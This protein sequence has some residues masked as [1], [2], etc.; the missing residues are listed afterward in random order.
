MKKNQK[1]LL[2]KLFVW[3]V[4]ITFWGTDI[5]A[6]GG[7]IV[8][9]DLT[10]T[11]VEKNALTTDVYT[12]SVVGENAYNAFSVFDVYEDNTVNL[13]LPENTENLLN[14]VY[15]KKS[16]IN[17][18]LNSYKDNKIG[19][20]VFFLNPH[21]I[22]VSSKGRINVG[23]LSLSTP[24]REFLD[25]LVDSHGNISS[26]ATQA[27]LDGDTPIDETGVISIDGQ[28]NAQNAIKVDSGNFEIK[29]EMS[30]NQ[31][32]DVFDLVVNTLPDAFSGNGNID[33]EAKNDIVA[34]K[35]SKISSSSDVNDSGDIYMWADKDAYLEKDSTISAVASGD[36]DAGNVEF[37][38]ND[39]V[40][41]RGG[42]LD[43]Y[44]EKGKSGY[45][46]VDP[47]E[48]Y[49]EDDYYSHAE[50]HYYLADE[51]I[52]ISDGV[53]ISSRAITFGKEDNRENHLNENSTASSG[54]LD[55]KADTIDVGKDVYIITK[56]NN[57]FASDDINMEAEKINLGEGSVLNAS[58][59]IDLK[60]GN[61]NLTAYHN[62]DGP[63]TNTEAYVKIEDNV[64]IKGYDVNISSKADCTRYLDE[65]YES[66][67]KVLD[68][69]DTIVPLPVAYS[70][71][72][73]DSKIEVGSGA[74][75]EAV[76][77]VNLDSEA[78]TD[79]SMTSVGWIANVAWGETNTYS[80][81]LLDG[82]Q[83]DAGNSVDINSVADT[84]INMKAIAIAFG[85]TRAEAA[86]A[87]GNADVI[88]K[89]NIDKDSN[90]NAA[91][92]V[93]V[94]SKTDKKLNVSAG[95]SAYEDGQLALAFAWSKSNIDNDAKLGGDIK[96]KNLKVG[97]EVN[98][99][100]NHNTATSQVGT[101]GIVDTLKITKVFAA[102]GG[103]ADAVKSKI[104]G[105]TPSPR[106]QSSSKKFGLSAAF[107]LSDHV[108]MSEA[109][110]LENTSVDASNN[111]TV[112]SKIAAEID[113]DDNDDIDHEN[114]KQ[115]VSAVVDSNPKHQK[116]NTAS[117]AISVSSYK[118]DSKAYIGD[119][120]EINSGG[121]LLVKSEN[122]KEH[123]FDWY[124]TWS[125]SDIMSK[126]NPTLGIQHEFTTWARSCADSAEGSGGITLSGSVNFTDFDYTS[127]AYI[128]EN[129][130][131]NQDVSK[132]T[133][134]QSV[135]VNSENVFDTL[136]MSGALGLKI[137]GS[138]GEKGALGGSYLDVDT[139]SS[140]KAIIKTGSQIYSDR[141]LVDA[142]SNAKHISI[143]A[144]GAKTGEYGVAGSFSALDQEDEVKSIVEKGVDIQTGS[145]DVYDL[146]NDAGTGKTILV[147]ANDDVQLLNITGGVLKGGNVGAGFAGGLNQIKRDTGA[148]VG[149]DEDDDISSRTNFDSQ[150]NILVR[151][152]NNG[153]IDNYSLA[154]AIAW[155]NKV[156]NPEGTMV[157]GKW[158]IGASGD[159]A[160]NEVEDDSVASIVNTD[161]QADDVMVDSDGTTD[162]F[163]ITGSA[164]LAAS[165]GTSVGLSGSVSINSIDSDTSSNIKDSN[166]TS[167]GKIS[168]EA[169]NNSTIKAWAV[170][171]TTGLST[172]PQGFS[173]V[174]SLAKNEITNDTNTNVDS[175]KLET[176]A[177]AFTANSHDSS[178]ITAIAGSIA[179][180][181]T[182]GIGAS[183]SINSIKNKTNT[184]AENSSVTSSDKVQ[185]NAINSSIIDNYGVSIGLETGYFAGATSINVNAIENETKAYIDGKLDDGIKANGGVIDVL[186]TDS[187]KIS[188]FAG[189]LGGGKY[190]GVGQNVAT[191]KIDNLTTSYAKD[192]RLE[193]NNAV[194]VKAT[195]NKDVQTIAAGAAAG[196]YFSAAGSVVTNK[197]V[198]QTSSKILSS[199][200]VA[201]DDTTVKAY[202]SSSIYNYAGNFSGSLEGAG[203]GGTV[204]YTYSGV[205]T[206]SVVDSSTFTKDSNI[207]INSEKNRDIST[208]SM[209]ITGSGSAAIAANVAYTKIKDKTK[210]KLKDSDITVK[211]LYV[212]TKANNYIS[213][214]I[215]GLTVG[216]DA[217]IGAASENIIFS[218]ENTSY[219]DNTNV[220]SSALV[221][222]NVDAV[223]RVDSI[224][225]SG[226]FSGAAGIAGSVVN[227]N[228]HND[229]SS[230]IKDSSIYANDMTVQ[231]SDEFVIG[232]DQP[233]INGSASV[234][235]SAGIGGTVTLNKIENTNYAYVEDSTSDVENDILLN[236]DSNYSIDSFNAIA[237]AGEYAG[238][239]GT[240]LVN[241]VKGDTQAYMKKDDGSVFVNSDNLTIQANGKTNVKS[242]V[243]AASGGAVG[244]GASVDVT[245][246]DNTVKATTGND[247]SIFIDGDLSVN[248]E[249]EKVLDSVVVGMAGGL[250]ALGGGIGVY[251]IGSSHDEDQQEAISGVDGNVKD[252]SEK[253][254]GME[255]KLQENDIL[256][257]SDFYSDI[258]ND[259]DSNISNDEVFAE[260]EPESSVVLAS[261]GDN[262]T[263]QANSINIVSDNITQ[264]DSTAGGATIG[265]GVGAG[266]GV[267]S[268]K[269]YSYAFIGSKSNIEADKDINII[270]KNN[271]RDSKF[272]SYA[273]AAGPTASLGASVI[274]VNNQDVS[275]AYVDAISN[276][277]RGE[278]IT[279]NARSDM[280]VEADAYGASLGM[281][282]AV[283]V[284]YSKVKKTGQTKAFLGSKSVIGDDDKN[285]KDVFIKS[286]THNNI[287]NDAYAGAAGIG[288]VSGAG[289]FTDNDINE[290][291]Y[292]YTDYNSSIT[293]ASDLWIT[294]D[295]N[296]D[297]D[298]NVYGVAAG[299]SLAV[300]F[301]KVNT[302]VYLDNQAYIGNLTKVRNDDTRV[303]AVQNT[304]VDGKSLAS[305]GA[306]VG[307][308]GSLAYSNVDGKVQ[309][310]IGDNV[311]LENGDDLRLKAENT[312][313][314][315]VK[316]SAYGGGIIAAGITK[317]DSKADV[318]G[319]VEIG[320]ASNIKVDKLDV[321]VKNQN[322]LFSES[323]AGKGGVV[324]GSVSFADTEDDSYSKAEF[325]EL[326][327][328]RANTID[329]DID[330]YSKANAKINT[331]NAAVVG[332]S[333][334]R[335]KNNIDVGSYI[336]LDSATIN[337]TDLNFNAYSNVDK[338]WLSDDDDNIFSG[339]GGVIDASAI[340]SD[341][342]SQNNA[343]IDINKSNIISYNK[344]KENT[345]T[346]DIKAYTENNLKDK[347]KIISG[348][349]IPIAK[350]ETYI[351]DKSDADVNLTNSNINT[352]G[353]LFI[354]SL[355][356]S[357][358]KTKVRVKTYGVS[359]VAQGS[360]KSSVDVDDTVNIKG[361]SVIK[362]KNVYLSTGIDHFGN[363][364]E[365]HAEAKADLFNNS[366]LPFDT[367]PYAKGSINQNHE[368]N[369]DSYAKID[370]VE[371]IT[372]VN[373]EG[374]I[375]LDGTAKAQNTY[376]DALSREDIE[377]KTEEDYSA[378]VKVD[379]TIA[380][381]VDNIQRLHLDKN[382]TPVEITNGIMFDITTDVV[383]DDIEDEIDRLKDLQNDYSEL[384]SAYDTYQN[385]ID[386]LEAQLDALSTPRTEANTVGLTLFGDPG[387]VSQKDTVMFD[388]HD[389]IASMGNI[390]VESDNLY[391]SG[392]MSANPYAEIKIT[393]DS[394]TFLRINDLIIPNKEGGKVLFN[395]TE[396]A[397][398]AQIDARNSSKDANF[399]LIDTGSSSVDPLIEV[400]N[401]YDPDFPGN[402]GDAPPIEINGNVENL[403]GTVRLHNDKG[404]IYSNGN[405]SA[406]T[407]D[408]KA[409]QDFVQGYVDGF[410]HVGGD[411]ATSDYWKEISRN[412][413][414]EVKHDREKNYGMFPND[415]SLSNGSVIAGNNVIISARYLNLNGLIQSGIPD[416]TIDIDANFKVKNQ[417]GS[418]ASSG[419]S[420]TAFGNARLPYS[421]KNKYITPEEARAKYLAGQAESKYFEINLDSSNNIKAYYNAETN[422]VELENVRIQGGY[423]ELYGEIFNTGGDNGRIKVLDG[424]GKIDIDNNSGYK[425]V[426]NNI[427]MGDEV[428]GTVK[429]TDTGKT[430]W[431]G[432]D[433]VT[434]YKRIGDEI[435]VYT[436]DT[437]DDEG[438]ASKL[439][440][441][442]LGR[443]S[444]YN[445]ESNKRYVWLTGLEHVKERTKKWE[446]NSWLGWD[447]LCKDKYETYD[448]TKDLSNH[449]L[450]EGEML[451][452]SSNSYEYYYDRSNVSLSDWKRTYKNT[453][454]TSTWYGKKTYHVKKKYKK[455]TK[456]YNKH[457]IKADYDV[458]IEFSGY[459]EGLLDILSGAGVEINGSIYNP[460]GNSAITS[461]SSGIV[462]NSDKAII[463]TKNLDLTSAHG[464]G[465]GRSIKTIINDGYIKAYTSNSN[466]NIENTQGDVK[467]DY[468]HANNGDVNFISDG[469]ITA[470][471]SNTVIRGNNFF[472]KSNYG[473]IGISTSRIVF[474]P[475]ASTDIT[476]EYKT[477]V[478]AQDSIYMERKAN[479][480]LGIDRIHSENGDVDLVTAA[481]IYDA[482]SNDIRDTRTETELTALWSD[483]VLRE[484]DGALDVA[485]EGVQA[486]KRTKEQEYSDYWNY[487]NRQ[488]D[489]SVHD[490]NFEVKL[491]DAERDSYKDSGYT[492]DQITEIEK[493][494]TEKYQSWKDV[495]GKDEYN[496]NYE[497]QVS[498]NEENAMTEGAVWNEAQLKNTIRDFGKV[499]S[500]STQLNIEEANIKGKNVKVVSA[501]NIGSD[502]G[503]TTIN[504]SDGHIFTE[505]EKLTLMAAETQDMILSDDE[506]YVTVLK[507]E[508]VDFDADSIDLKASG[509]VYVGSE[510]DMFL[511][512]IEAAQ[513]KD[514]RIKG[515]EGIYDVSYDDSPT[516]IA[517]D[518]I[519][520]GSNGNIGTVDNPLLIDLKNGG[521][522]TA[523][524]GGDI[525]LKE[526]SGDTYLSYVYTKGLFSFE[527]ANDLL[528][529]DG[530]E[531]DNIRA[532]TLD[533]TVPG[534]IGLENNRINVNIDDVVN[535]DTGKDIHL[536]N[537]QRP[538]I[539]GDVK[540]NW[541]VEIL[542]EQDVLANET[543]NVRGDG[544]FIEAYNSKIGAKD[545]PINIE[546]NNHGELLADNDIFVNVNQSKNKF[547]DFTSN[548]GNINIYSS[549]AFEFKENYNA[550]QGTVYVNSDGV[551]KR[552]NGTLN[553]DNIDI[554]SKTGIGASDE[555]FDV[556]QAG[557]LWARSSSDGS[558]YLNLANADAVINE[559]NA[560]SISMTSPTDIVMSG[561]I[562]GT[563]VKLT[564][565]GSI[566]DE[567]N[568]A[569]V[570]AN[571]IELTAT[572]GSI[573][574]FDRYF[575]I[576]SQNVNATAQTGIYLRKDTKDLN[577]NQMTLGVKDDVYMQ[578]QN[579][580]I[581]LKQLNNIE[582]VNL[583]KSGDVRLFVE[584]T[585]ID[586]NPE[587]PAP[588]TPPAPAGGGSEE[589]PNSDIDVPVEP[590]QPQPEEPVVEPANEPE[591]PQ[592]EEPAV[593]PA[594]EPEQP[595][596]EEPAVE[597]AN[598]PEQPQPE[599]PAVEPAN[600]PEQPQPEE[601]AVEPANEPEQP[602]SEE[603]AVEP[604]NEPEQPQPEEPAVEPANEPEQP[605]S[606]E[607]AEKQGTV[608][609]ETEEQQPTTNN[610]PKTE[611][612][613]SNGE[614]GVGNGE[615]DKSVITQPQ[616]TNNES[617]TEKQITDE[618]E[619]QNDNDK[620]VKSDDDSDD[621]DDKD[622]DDE[623][624]DDEE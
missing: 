623:E 494:R 414:E 42:N 293:T 264:V 412:S 363:V 202:D 272:K 18:I 2:K 499:E 119:D 270:S 534:Y 70:Y 510:K 425:L 145:G 595:Q 156:E 25:Q 137:S 491:T 75:I 253:V 535:F 348:G 409:G 429:I 313:D 23:S 97:S 55:F 336:Y 471:D 406:K 351:D 224:N 551:I 383:T 155:A 565:Q 35:D 583:E 576:D 422:K 482:N 479:V 48:I 325:K 267:L 319:K 262:S 433:K 297:V 227:I 400:K 5:L 350:A 558:V 441:T 329:L 522:L 612:D 280:D 437:V 485:D 162:I 481:G 229:N 113:R 340:K 204:I 195:S 80:N 53:T 203:L 274:V 472:I 300:G 15:D 624:D 439:L 450:L 408:I 52:D 371:D 443:V 74:K 430:S 161:S 465:D 207:N 393:N 27:V 365:Y 200:I 14:L 321:E 169:D 555:Y 387:P 144:S 47:K 216:G 523:R 115:I 488:D 330:N 252:Q 284:A 506:S 508:D 114:I 37:S 251:N 396:V 46:L 317:S 301:S 249:D 353:D 361:S 131:I 561:N 341:T 385:R 8:V 81:I 362:A 58:N 449:A 111:L 178:E 147:D 230:Y 77:D 285:I 189:S 324:A 127:K 180:G 355:S 78:I 428:E 582:S 453:W 83:I 92:N 375:F 71:S 533:L 223:S 60:A 143:A 128:G 455:G 82:A 359:A 532:K 327:V 91:E 294:T 13:Y 606:E 63:I 135:R 191:N 395:G 394:Q 548:H 121:R 607:P 278:N 366:A 271:L 368:I 610:E 258:Q 519:L 237:A 356:D 349:A 160:I 140:S 374:Y 54:I 157:Q 134:D 174:G 17:G 401:T 208:N 263:V 370:S 21:G 464:I 277:K 615:L 496:E 192:T 94:F 367:D 298:S 314:Q 88:N 250:G 93:S 538:L 305:S 122:L 31:S 183:I 502:N 461:T 478:L 462:N 545:N 556:D 306:L 141:M 295:G 614:L 101:S 463:N 421:A 609:S 562:T 288:F 12:E 273:G 102:M 474:D 240:V 218:D 501:G 279:I 347:V 225:V 507:R 173:L 95:A 283:G 512:K 524:A 222:N 96:A 546:Y 436:N 142:D 287:S 500:S 6:S 608:N 447:G 151:S 338:A 619:S 379:G 613:E 231:S 99:L 392:S 201:G 432:E 377:S 542:S 164:T 588:P 335:I 148:F 594:N 106:P 559:V 360:T 124:K 475:G 486:Y 322:T 505:D 68:M 566:L 291:V 560:G 11:I 104:T 241:T 557:N 212:D 402:D 163:S 391:G 404:S 32:D 188:S 596:S 529:A 571:N 574:E 536:G 598:E 427:D 442:Q 286:E 129:V 389:V 41:I 176:T 268:N 604:A 44:A 495:Y 45:T 459:D 235:G 553:T 418:G 575:N 467:I 211:N 333:G 190:G 424:F 489:P 90:I 483:L 498:E 133:G 146:D 269:N 572:T 56:A 554:Y 170:S 186:A 564:A 603:P 605:Q 311:N 345:G 150:G 458:A 446:D 34:N 618:N 308:D 215:G 518:L 493:D 581:E 182:S 434:I 466:I 24:T 600:E 444:D 236:A 352:T 1:I 346:I 7:M 20:N 328:I 165:N 584:G 185:F 85:G 255:G 509:Y 382:G 125:P 206:E 497:Y 586:L 266:V 256:P 259:S 525:Y 179:A 326:A 589:N 265:D 228:S 132:R 469:D 456:T 592:P 275:K 528:N 384:S 107:A 416:K 43:A 76:Q 243:A 541:Y 213:D 599:E 50:N 621:D 307:V 210:S 504:L 601:P 38:A 569:I 282:G 59:S 196:K 40:Y 316:A 354:S 403:S 73:A 98:V 517:N 110:L 292:A 302:D 220:D 36:R 16:N 616:T 120:S 337:A 407:I 62:F 530:D 537:Y 318:S 246:I 405:I 620:S 126:L 33:I 334:G 9:N 549:E 177:G 65:N 331:I 484:E 372:L 539:L 10:R 245:S 310:K 118:N 171:S 526:V 303:Y 445:P 457:S 470:L 490:D 423:V 552:G 511:K 431:L 611:S 281:G 544:V 480:D 19:G 79:S 199:T 339:S 602:Q 260:K 540:S 172:K 117:A 344:D 276:I 587:P 29:G 386:E 426:L 193:T 415:D 357:D 622:D 26:M 108:N 69:L 138:N 105:N 167:N 299:N 448:E 440:Y 378:K 261:I 239:A 573:G 580:T 109:A 460:D 420:F 417:L 217:G 473:G 254:S 112:N 238:V 315:N 130:K 168:M 152:S 438:N 209:N 86:F 343:K 520:E 397:S 515:K 503:E 100:K 257:D 454:T 358:T 304:D 567:N 380:A 476:K 205:N 577:S 516:I 3:I 398:N 64:Q 563:D 232:Y 373:N 492:D 87:Y 543:T 413:E 139:L 49:I 468:F 527:G 72:K 550:S 197:D 531:T 547:T 570:K 158:A 419:G 51:L 388:L 296:S 320:Q 154:G 153:Q 376:D 136:H 514:V 521:V 579:G 390:K 578:V 219:I 123:I 233:L 181:N 30:S 4:I 221:Q 410:F 332:A 248:A 67:E 159:V 435:N 591:Q 184:Y 309:S 487:R 28:V 381:G 369:I 290:D 590:E 617:Q 214:K 411:P 39:R 513:D 89:I 247:V 452:T 116:A 342:T 244:I 61:V 84:N 451:E 477:T 323:V 226:A 364:G 198:S 187:S 66:V 166:V 22:V 593:E 175:S 399:N 194:N 312:S 242:R 149:L 57:G 234:G 289:A 103:L 568:N 597:P 585:E